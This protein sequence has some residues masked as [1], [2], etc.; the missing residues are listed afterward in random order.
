[1]LFEYEYLQIIIH[2]LSFAYIERLETCT[3]TDFRLVSADATNTPTCIFGLFFSPTQIVCE[4][5]IIWLNP[6][7]TECQTTLN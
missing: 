2:V 1:M 6:V 3:N 5:I 7:Y 4:S